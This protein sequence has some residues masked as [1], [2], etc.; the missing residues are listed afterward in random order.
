M[1]TGQSNYYDTYKYLL[2]N[3]CFSL[4]LFLDYSIVNLLLLFNYIIL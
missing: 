4:F 3:E 1:C 2:K